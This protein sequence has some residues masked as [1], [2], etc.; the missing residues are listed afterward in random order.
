MYS[1]QTRLG[2]GLF[3]SLTVAF[4]LLW[5]ATSATIR[6]LAENYIHSRLQ[7]DSETILGSL[8]F[9]R[10]NLA[11]IDKSK[12]NIIFQRPFSGHYFKVLTGEQQIRSRSLWDQDLA[13]ETLPSGKK[14]NLHLIG[15][16]QKP[17]LVYV[18]SYLKQNHPVTIA[19]AEDLSHIELALTDFQWK[20]SLSAIL[21]LL[22]LILIQVY[23]VRDSIRPLNKIR[24]DLRALERGELQ[25]LDSPVPSEISPLIKEINRLINITNQRLQRSRNSLGDLAHALKKPLTVL[26]QL[27]HDAAIQ[28]RPDIKRTLDTQ[29]RTMHQSM[30][31]VLKRAR[32]A[33]E[34]PAVNYFSAHKEVSSLIDVLKAMYRE[35]NLDFVINIPEDAVLSNDRE[36]MLELLGNI[37]ENACKWTQQKIAITVQL[38]KDILILIEDDG[39]GADE[40]DLNRLSERGT[41]LDETTEGHGIGLAIAKDII[42]QYHGKLKFGRSEKLGGFCVSITLPENHSST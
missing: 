19:V 2:S 24:E 4:L 23:I 1:L 10:Q 36:D 30:E 18:S 7:H 21:V 26:S 34:G 11:I 40:N 5:L 17:L 33:G 32:L 42:E 35:K 16:E 8:D 15:P 28:Q 20:F 12:L 9:N 39:A 6:Y 14:T 22:L 13:I 3:I 38:N 37:M 25:S 41:R 29:T 31:R 27:S